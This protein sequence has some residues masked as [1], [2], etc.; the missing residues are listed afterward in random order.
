MNGNAMKAP[1]ESRNGP[2]PALAER[3]ARVTQAIASAVHDPVG[4]SE[5]ETIAAIARRNL[6]RA[7][8]RWSAL[9]RST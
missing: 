8:A 1:R 3:S 6:T 9:S 2:R 4:R 7:S 5:T